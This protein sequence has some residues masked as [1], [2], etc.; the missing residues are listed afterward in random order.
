MYCV[1]WCDLDLIQGRRRGHRAFELPT[2]ANNCTFPGLSPLPLSRVAQNWWL[3]VIVWHLVYSLL[4][5]IFDFPSRKA[6]MRVQ[7]S[8]NVDISQHS[9]RHI[10]VLRDATVRWLGMLVVL[11]VLWMLIW[12]WPNPRSRSRSWGFWISENEQVMHAWRQW[13]SAPFWGFLVTLVTNIFKLHSYRL[14][15]I[16]CFPTYSAI[17]AYLFTI[18][19]LFLWQ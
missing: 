4:E 10:S 13:P 2:I 15:L 1:R 8:R 18:Y 5:P 9:N 3:A 12:P 19:P 16:D 17:T 6:I 14:F 11:Q 7:T